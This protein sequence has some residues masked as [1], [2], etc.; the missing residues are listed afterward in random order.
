M[1]KK[2]IGIVGVGNVGSTLAFL[3]ATN[4]LCSEILLKDIR[5][6]FT[7]AIALDISQSVCDENIVVK[8]CNNEDF[9]DCDIVVIT[10]GIARKENMSREELLLTN[11]KIVS[12]VFDD[13]LENN[14]NA[15]FIIVSNPLDAMVY[16]SLKKTSLPRNRIF[17]M[18]GALDSARFKYYIAEKLNFNFKNIEAM[19]IGSHSNSM[20]PLI[21]HSFVDGKRLSEIFTKDELD[22]IIDNTKNGGTK[23][24]EL[25]KTTS[26]YF[27]PA[28]AIFS[29]CTAIIN[30]TKE[31]FSCC[32][33]LENEYGCNDITM[34]VPVVLGKNGLENVVKFD[35]SK[36]ELALFKESSKTVE[37]SIEIIKKEFL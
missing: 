33:M 14:K 18:A 1:T 13:I 8:A 29:M 20:L 37:S 30:D 35:L 16:V 11:F 23:L 9:K 32:C 26:A 7:K 17:G 25:F 22:L 3:L 31:I 15:I 24:V 5:E 21:N 19:V 34:G 12:S 28:Y 4:R 2:R 10:A 27:T 36:D 6:N